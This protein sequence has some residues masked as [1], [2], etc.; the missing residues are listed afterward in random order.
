MSKSASE[1]TA[2]PKI[3]K[4]EFLYEKGSFQGV[5]KL[6][7]FYDQNTFIDPDYRLC[8]LYSS[9]DCSSFPNTKTLLD[10]FDH[11]K[12]LVIN[13]N[14]EDA[15]IPISK[16]GSLNTD[17]I[18]ISICRSDGVLHLNFP[19]RNESEETDEILPG[20]DASSEEPKE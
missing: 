13:I 20:N 9:R 8:G 1:R 12:L 6:V 19:T 14:T 4:D 18:E 10:A 15:Y 17:L 16:S 11:G 2:N 7:C 5:S 3:R